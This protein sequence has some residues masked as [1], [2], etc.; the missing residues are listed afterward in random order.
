L[1]IYREDYR[2]VTVIDFDTFG[3]GEREID[4]GYFLAQSAITGFLQKGDFASTRRQRDL[5]LRD[6][7]RAAG[8]I[9]RARLGVYEGIAFLQ[10]LHYELDVLHTG[11]NGLIEPWLGMSEKFL[12]DGDTDFSYAA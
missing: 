11:N 12:Y 3:W 8:E 6:Y 2:R 9:D 10:S 5:F 4:V 1:N 7:V